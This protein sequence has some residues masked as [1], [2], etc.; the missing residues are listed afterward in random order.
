VVRD[1]LVA[2]PYVHHYENDGVL[3]LFHALTLQ[4]IYGTPNL[5]DVFERF[6]TAASV[7]AVAR[8]FGADE[9][10]A[11]AAI[12]AL[13]SE[14]FLQS[15]RNGE[16][17]TVEALKRRAL[18]NPL[19]FLYLVPTAR[20]NLRCKY[21]HILE[22]TSDG[23]AS[24]MTVE[25]AQ[26]SLDVFIRNCSDNPY[27][28]EVMFYGGEPMLNRPV[29]MSAVEYIRQ[30]ERLFNGD[31]R[32]TLFTNGTIIDEQTARFLANHAVFVIVSMDGPK[33]V[34]DK[35]RVTASGNG[36]FARVARGYFTYKNAGC[37]V[38]ISLVIGR[39]NVPGLARA[40]EQVIDLF[41]PLDLGLST[42]HLFRGGTNPASVPTEK[43]A[44]ELIDT[45]ELVRDRG[46]Y[47][48]HIF[49]RVRPFVERQPRLKDCPSCGAKLLV[50]PDEKIGFCEAFMESGKYF[51]DMSSFD[52]FHNDGYIEWSRVAP[53]LRE[54]CLRCACVA[55]CGGGCPYDAYSLHGDINSPDSLRC[56]QS[57]ILLEWLVRDLFKQ[58]NRPLPHDWDFVVPTAEERKRIYGRIDVADP[59][60]PLQ[61]YSR[62]GEE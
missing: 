25:T 26:R 2:S 10:H 28:K 36:S 7:Q 59:D 57:H 58:T 48:E 38:G 21:C 41:Q 50:T 6:R 5:A 1:I 42:L 19:R 4:N 33:E 8:T 45:F 37:R 49:R 16:T 22:N 60:I 61:H 17:E 55:I 34:H 52:R 44:R 32:I 20:C 30:K 62:F 12:A 53:I 27:E 39:H 14:G 35:M 56:E 18:A 47:A 11:R 9:R 43:L 23:T 46:V 3:C 51:Y 31:V 29:V 54:E 13:E 15:P 24:D 40:V